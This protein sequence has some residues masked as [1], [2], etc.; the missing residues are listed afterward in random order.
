MTS[1]LTVTFS[2]KSPLLQCNFLPEI[3]L[4]EDREYSC[5]LLDLIIKTNHKFNVQEIV[6]LDLLYINCDIISESYING[7][8]NQIIHQFATRAA[9]AKGQTFAEVPKHLN[10]FPIKSKTLRSIQISVVDSNGNL[11]KITGGEI[12][13]RINIRRDQ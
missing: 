1:S 6:N 8:H 13:C 10:Y 9:V 7:V 5:A 3:V 4:D 12:S 2:G 11:I